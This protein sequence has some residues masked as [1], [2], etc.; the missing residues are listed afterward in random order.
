M[1]GLSW[2][3]CH[4]RV[5][6]D[7]LSWT[8]PTISPFAASHCPLR[9]AWIQALSVRTGPVRLQGPFMEGER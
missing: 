8:G 7:Q 5:V 9:H 6:M 3:G 4:G 1:D 2:T